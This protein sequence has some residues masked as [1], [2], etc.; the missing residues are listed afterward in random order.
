QFVIRAPGGRRDALRK[1]LA[2][3]GVG[4]EIYYPVPLHMQ[5]CFGYLGWQKGDLPQTELAAEETLALP[6][7]PELTEAEQRTVVGRIAEFFEVRQ[8][9][10]QTDEIRRTHQ[11]EAVVEEPH[12]VRRMNAVGRAD[13]VRC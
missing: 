5:Q 4:T 7:F 8:P 3:C 13:D 1:H 10:Q 2:A 11:P 6:I 9:Q 12:F